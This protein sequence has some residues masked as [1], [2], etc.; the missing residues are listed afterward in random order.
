MP[1]GGGKGGGGGGTVISTSFLISPF[2][3]VLYYSD[4][5]PIRSEWKIW[6][7]GFFR[8]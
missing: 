3:Q 8:F 6:T 5:V 4:G 2:P 1:G 7:D